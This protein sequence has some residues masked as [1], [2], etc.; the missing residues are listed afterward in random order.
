MELELMEDGLSTRNQDIL[1]RLF[2][3][4]SSLD[5]LTLFVDDDLL[6][7]WALN[8]M[9][10]FSALKSLNVWSSYDS[11]FPLAGDLEPTLLSDDNVE[12]PRNLTKFIVHTAAD[13]GTEAFAH[14]A[15]RVALASSAS[16]T[17][18]H[19][20]NT[21]PDSLLHIDDL[22][23]YRHQ[24]RPRFGNLRH[25]SL[26]RIVL[27][28]ETMST[29]LHYADEMVEIFPRL[30]RL[31]ISNGTVELLP[32]LRLPTLQI[33][34]IDYTPLDTF[35]TYLRKLADAPWRTSL[36]E[37]TFRTKKDKIGDIT[38]S[39]GEFFVS[40]LPLSRRFE[41]LRRL[42][43]TCLAGIH[44]SVICAALYAAPVL[45]DLQVIGK[46]VD[47]TTYGFALLGALYA[48]SEIDLAIF[49]TRATDELYY[50]CNNMVHTYPRIMHIDKLTNPSMSLF[51]RLAETS[52]CTRQFPRI[53][54]DDASVK[55]YFRKQ[56]LQNVVAATD[57]AD[58]IANEACKFLTR[59]RLIDFFSTY[60]YK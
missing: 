19:L 39:W 51:L 15:M 28:D 47:I 44:C 31:Y 3:C 42:H 38:P 30:D 25:L 27:N 10:Q 56:A 1:P 40:D 18:F 55:A 7:P 33:L 16:L 14:N 5:T 23:E 17:E 34:S 45:R 48:H 12:L 24:K 54:R 41:N 6:Q 43:I 50:E 53:P 57:M 21:Q 32:I 49:I 26:D 37:L 36:Q 60:Y 22:V 59:E 46:I 9:A 35:W 20:R 2:K 52:I 4:I 13:V 11:T 8:Q 29:A 58:S